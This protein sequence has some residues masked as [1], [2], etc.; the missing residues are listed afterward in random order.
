[1]SGTSRNLG[2]PVLLRSI[3]SQTQKVLAY[4]IYFFHMKQMLPKIDHFERFAEPL[5]A[6]SNPHRLRIIAILKLHGR[7]YVS[8]LARMAEMSRPLLYLHLE[9]L[10]TAKLV[11]SHLS[12]SPEGKAL[13][14]F[15]VCSFEMNLSPEA[16][17]A[18]V[19]NDPNKEKRP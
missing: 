11:K 13:R 10:E 8:E 2:R 5:A 3:S 16:I 14:W 6:L 17:A 12:L 4:V 19:H 15:E 18:V 1:M 7:Q 9:K